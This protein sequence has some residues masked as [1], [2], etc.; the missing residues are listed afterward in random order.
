V[1]KLDKMF[2]DALGSENNST[3]IIGTLV[4][5]ARNMDIEI[6]AEGVETFEQVIALRERGIR[7]VQGYVFAPPL[8][9]T[10]F[11]RLI[12]ATDHQAQA[13]ESKAAAA[14]SFGFGYLSSRRRASA[15]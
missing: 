14:V 4:E 5:L 13:N 6:I 11:L 1:I 7:S 8:P 3:A 10:S 12:E 9:G 2:V 15:A